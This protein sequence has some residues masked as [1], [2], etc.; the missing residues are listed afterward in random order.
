M[1]AQAVFST[2]R[3]L[4]GHPWVG[5]SPWSGTPASPI[6]RG[7]FVGLTG[8]PPGGRL[9]LLPSQAGKRGAALSPRARGR[10]GREAG[11]AP[12]RA[13]R[14]RAHGGGPRRAPGRSLGP[15]PRRLLCRVAPDDGLRAAAPAACGRTGG[16]RSRPRGRRLPLLP[17]QGQRHGRLAGLGQRQPAEVQ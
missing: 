7:R 3:R 17:A 10:G 9:R 4:T 6:R 2:S 16:R 8:V 1:R 13:G 5:E 15:G 14:G 12:P 11:R